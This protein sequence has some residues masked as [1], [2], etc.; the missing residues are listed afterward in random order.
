VSV[1]PP[2]ERFPLT[3]DQMKDP[4]AKDNGVN[5]DVN[6]YLTLDSTHASFNYVWIANSGYNTVSKIDSKTVREV[7]RYVSATC[8]SLKTGSTQ[9]CDGTNGCCALDDWTRYQARKNKMPQPQ[10]QAAQLT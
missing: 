6:G 7:A 1:G 3:S 10:H 5:R 8:F 4:A 2:G 9:Q